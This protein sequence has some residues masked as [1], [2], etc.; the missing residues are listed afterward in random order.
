MLRSTA[1]YRQRVTM[2]ELEA[3]ADVTLKG[4]GASNWTIL[5]YTLSTAS[6][7][8]TLSAIDVKDN[9]CVTLGWK[10]MGFAHPLVA[11]AKYRSYTKMTPIAWER[12]LYLIMN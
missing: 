3:Y 10:S 5:L 6:S 7:L 4:D 12:I 1:V 8:M 11:G 2:H 9:F